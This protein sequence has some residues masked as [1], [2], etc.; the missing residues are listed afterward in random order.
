MD[1]QSAFDRAEVAVAWEKA[2]V[3][4]FKAFDAGLA[5]GM[6][7]DMIYTV[8]CDTYANM[9]GIRL[10]STIKVWFDEWRVAK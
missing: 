8:S 3:A 2:K 7:L 5:H 4:M 1:V 6:P 10:D 9:N